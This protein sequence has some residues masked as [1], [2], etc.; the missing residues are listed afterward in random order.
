MGAGY[1]GG[2]VLAIDGAGEGARVHDYGV[3]VEGEGLISFALDARRG[4]CYAVSWPSGAFVHATLPGFE[5]H[6][7]GGELATSEEFQAAGMDAAATDALRNAVRGRESFSLESGLRGGI[8][9]GLFGGGELAEGTSDAYQVLPRTL[10]VD[11]ETGLL[12]MT[13]Q[14][15]EIVAYSPAMRDVVVLSTSMRLKYFGDVRVGAGSMGF[16]LRQ[17]MWHARE[18]AFLA[19]HGNSGYLYWFDPPRPGRPAAAI[20]LLERICSAPSREAGQEDMFS[21]GYLG[22]CLSSDGN[23][24]VYLTGGPI[25]GVSAAK[26]RTGRGEALGDENCHV[27]SYD[28][29]A[30]RLVDHGAIVF[31]GGGHPTFV[32]SLA[33]A[34]DGT[35]FSCGRPDPGVERTMPFVIE[36]AELWRPA[37]GADAPSAPPAQAVPRDHLWGQY[38]QHC[39]AGCAWDVDEGVYCDRLSAAPGD[40]V[41]LCVSTSRARQTLLVFREG[42]GRVLVATHS[43]R[44]L[45]LQPTRC[46]DN[47][48]DGG[49]GEPCT[50]GFGWEITYR[51]PIPR[52]W[53]SGVYVVQVETGLGPREAMF[54]VRPAEGAARA[55]VAWVLADFTLQAYNTAGGRSSYNYASRDKRMATRLSFDR[56]QALGAGLGTFPAWD[57]PFLAFLARNGYCVDFYSQADLLCAGSNPLVEGGYA[58][59]LRVGHDEYVTRSEVDHMTAFVEQGGNLA[60]FGGNTFFWQVRTE[61]AGRTLVCHKDA[62]WGLPDEASRDPVRERDPEA[63]TVL[64]NDLPGEAG[65]LVRSLIGVTQLGFHNFLW[66]PSQQAM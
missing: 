40:S 11:P 30:R 22:L 52:T 19:T 46:S 14:G 13:L 54:V 42:D 10:L 38:E 29:Y 15:G 56:P 65:R 34:P 63:E 23:R 66:K 27:V 24:V 18:R 12:Y 39:I 36:A 33:M 48:G 31:D 51:L 45:R 3:P 20:R 62:A 2:H 1:S 53:P 57:A 32:N 5:A 21:Y 41:G 50:D 49:R 17:G 4:H 58:L 9:H 16:H 35:L 60:V 44:G 28:L 43:L 6:S 25:D 7:A 59:C 26:E 55:P 64:W 37:E 8:I 61:A 47:S